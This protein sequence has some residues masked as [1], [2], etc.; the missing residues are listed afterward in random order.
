MT[1]VIFAPVVVDFSF[2]VEAVR[3][4][5][6]KKRSRGSK[7]RCWIGEG[8]WKVDKREAGVVDKSQIYKITIESVR[9]LRETREEEEWDLL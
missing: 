9:G 1:R 7:A 5:A 4:Q 8:N 6:K 2:E 3:V